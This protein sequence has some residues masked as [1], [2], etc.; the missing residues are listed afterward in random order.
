MEMLKEFATFIIDTGTNGMVYNFVTNNIIL[1]G[2]IAAV[3]PWTW[4]NRFIDMVKNK[5]S[6]KN[7][8]S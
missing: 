3:T 5:I 7:D 1:L 4:D 2:A 6:G 8:E